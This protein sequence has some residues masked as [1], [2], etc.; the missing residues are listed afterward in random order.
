MATKE[1]QDFVPDYEEEETSRPTSASTSTAERQVIFHQRTTKSRKRWRK[2]SCRLC[3]I[4]STHIARH[5]AVAH[6]PWWYKPLS[7]CWICGVQEGYESKLRAKHDHHQQDPSNKNFKKKWIQWAE[8][9][10]LILVEAFSVGTIKDLLEVV[11]S[12]GLHTK[13]TPSNTETP[14]IIKELYLGLSVKLGSTYPKDGIFTRPPNCEAALMDWEVMTAILESCSTDVRE[15]IRLLHVENEDSVTKKDNSAPIDEGKAGGSAVPLPVVVSLK[16][17]K[18]GGSAVVLPA[19]ETSSEDE[20]QE[21]L[22]SHGHLDIFLS[23]NRY[24]SLSDYEKVQ[25][26]TQG[27]VVRLQGIVT[28][29]VFPNHWRHRQTILADPRV[30]C[31]F[32]I[33]PHRCCQATVSSLPRWTR[34]L[35]TLLEHPSCV[36][37]G[38]VGLDYYRTSKPNQEIQ[39]TF[40]RRVLD[41][42]KTGKHVLVL[43]CRDSGDGSAARDV[44]QLITEKLPSHVKIHR[45]CFMGTQAELK[46]WRQTFK[47][48]YFGVTKIVRDSEET[49]SA[50]K[51]VPLN[52]VLLESDC[53]YLGKAPAD[54]IPAARELA[55]IKQM[56]V[57]AVLAHVN[58][59]TEDLYGFSG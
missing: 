38:E 53:P 36:G 13:V 14:E 11:V 5:V 31:T 22:D 1:E 44:L 51:T 15:R 45:H 57:D 55:S 18:S 59:N 6:L 28:N 23:R 19:Q 10:L 39:F 42:L 33:H 58:R 46:Q 27:G 49:K 21:V 24:Q 9:L 34:E 8:E 40:L 26:L 47:N 20:V 16:A 41:L 48:C 37:L 35:T 52:R 54:V 30:R 29:F 50:L 56:T 25:D 4:Q 17:D 2:N 32:G 43:H 7:A 12:T 3:G